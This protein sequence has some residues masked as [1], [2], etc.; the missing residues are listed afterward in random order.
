MINSHASLQHDIEHHYHHEHDSHDSHADHD[1]K[2]NLNTVN[3]EQ[4]LLE[5]SIAESN[6]LQ[7]AVKFV[8]PN[9]NIFHSTLFSK[10]ISSKLFR[11]YQARAP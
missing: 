4:C 7:N 1:V 8:F 3:C 6:H 10:S 2:N 9:E 11:V 5:H